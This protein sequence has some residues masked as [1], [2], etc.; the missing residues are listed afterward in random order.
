LKIRAYILLEN[1]INALLI[2]LRDK[3]MLDKSG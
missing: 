2:L 3:S 1:C